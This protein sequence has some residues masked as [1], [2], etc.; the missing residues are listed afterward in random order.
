MPWHAV[1]LIDP[2]IKETRRFFS[3]PGLFTK[4]VKFG[5]LVFI[6]SMLSGSGGNFNPDFTMPSDFDGSPE[7]SASVAEAFSGLALAVN[8]NLDFILMAVIVGIVVLVVIAVILT[9]LKNMCFFAI[10]ECASTNKVNIIAYLRKSYG[11]AVSLTLVEVVF[12]LISLPFLAILILAGLSFFFFL[13]G[14]D[15]SVLGPFAGLASNYVL[16]TLLVILSLIALIVLSI[17][18]FV[19]GQFAAYWMHLSKMGAWQAFKKSLALVRGNLGQVLLLVLMQIVLGIVAAIIGILVLIIV[20]IPFV[21]I[22]ILAALALAPMLLQSPAVLLFAILLL[23]LGIFAFAFVTSIILAP[24]TLFFVNYS[25][26]FLKK[27]KG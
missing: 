6:F 16:M 4:W 12:S 27:L 2:A 20:A 23:I 26:M 14:V 24:I 9:I 1:D 11:K 10:L 5:I 17:A 19:L 3:G 25:L 13:L 21:L 18:G 8:Q 15:A 22:A 7:V